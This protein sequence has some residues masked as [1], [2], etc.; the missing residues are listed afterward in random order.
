MLYAEGYSQR[1]IAR[2]YNVSLGCVGGIVRFLNWAWLTSEYD[3]AL[4]ERLDKPWQP[5]TYEGVCYDRANKRW[6]ARVRV[7]GRR[8][9]L[10]YFASEQEVLAAWERFMEGMS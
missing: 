2:A 10:G 4:L 8:V 1:Q 6:K 3:D 5:S 7:S 9:H